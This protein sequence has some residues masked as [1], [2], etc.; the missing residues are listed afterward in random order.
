MR[1]NIPPFPTHV[2]VTYTGTTSNVLTI[3]YYYYLFS[4]VLQRGLWPPS[5]RGFLITQNDAPQSVGVLWTSDQ[6]VAETSTLQHNIHNRQ[7]PI[8]PMGF[9]SMIAVGKRP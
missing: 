6:L 2:F 8:P 5:S 7:T 3:Y 1:G 4:L 9:E